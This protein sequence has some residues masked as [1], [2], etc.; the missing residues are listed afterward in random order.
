MT[1]FGDSG[2]AKQIATS[3]ES[4]AHSKI[5]V[6]QWRNGHSARDQLGHH[7]AFTKSGQEPNGIKL[8]PKQSRN[9]EVVEL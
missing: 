6:H 4:V 8:S 2:E 3:E 5:L 9:R 7:L 1:T